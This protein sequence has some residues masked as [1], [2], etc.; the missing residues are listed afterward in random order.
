M[1]APDPLVQEQKSSAGM[2]MK[3]NKVTIRLKDFKQE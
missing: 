2:E 1:K 3:R